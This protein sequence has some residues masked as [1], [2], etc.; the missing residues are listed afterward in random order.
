MGK[1]FLFRIL[2]KTLCTLCN[3][4]YMF[5]SMLSKVAILFS[6]LKLFSCSGEELGE[7]GKT[8]S[9]PH[10]P[11]TFIQRDVEFIQLTV[12]DFI[13]VDYPRYQF[14]GYDERTEIFVD[15]IFYSPDSLRVFA[16][17][18]LKC[19]N[20]NEVTQ[21]QGYYFNGKALVG[22][23]ENPNEIWKIYPY[24]SYSASVF[25]KYET[26][27]NFLTESYMHR[28]KSYVDGHHVKVGYNVGDPRF[29]KSP[30]WEKGHRVPGYYNFELGTF[31]KPLRT[32]RTNYP[33]ELLEQFKKSGE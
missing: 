17:V 10:V 2:K 31:L 29:W 32:L 3:G 21:K 20:N 25:Q 23:R 27:Q 7:P 15:R 12:R 33:P 4:L 1:H 16:F 24:R 8:L 30:I 26:V 6:C 11:D 14:P 18:I 28:L 22:Y 13:R 9:D 5:K 19:Y